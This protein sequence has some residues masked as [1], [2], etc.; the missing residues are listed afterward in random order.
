MKFAARIAARSVVTTGRGTTG[1]G[2]TVAAVKEGGQWA[3]EAGALVLADGGL[4]CIDE[5]DGIK[6][7]D[8]ATIH[9][10]MEQQTVHIAKVGRGVGTS[11]VC[12]VL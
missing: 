10:A 4:C 6:E 1:A 3:L 8:R 12:A 2:L 9:E 11:G 5:F 7:A